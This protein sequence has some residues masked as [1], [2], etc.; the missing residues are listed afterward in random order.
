[1]FNLPVLPEDARWPKLEPHYVPNTCAK[2]LALAIVEQAVIDWKDLCKKIPKKKLNRSEIEKRKC[3]FSEI[4]C[5]FKSDWCSQLCGNSIR[6]SL[7]VEELER[8]Y[9]KSGYFKQLKAFEN[10]DLQC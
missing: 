5:F 10:G 2:E 8:C 1:M 3:M 9:Q 7:M 4:R 6:R